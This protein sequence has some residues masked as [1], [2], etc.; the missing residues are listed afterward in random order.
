[1]RKNTGQ[2]LEACNYDV[3]VMDLMNMK[4]GPRGCGNMILRD[5]SVPRSKAVC[6]SALDF[7]APPVFTMSDKAKTPLASSSTNKKIKVEGAKSKSKV[8]SKK[9]TAS[10]ASANTTSVKDERKMVSSLCGNHNVLGC[11]CVH[12]EVK[13]EEDTTMS[14]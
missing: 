5:N 8:R 1:M 11:D 12:G 2:S 14:G 9:P 3:V 10:T 4:P 6:L 7:N 13:I